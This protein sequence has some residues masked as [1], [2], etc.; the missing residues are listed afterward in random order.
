[1]SGIIDYGLVEAAQRFVEERITPN[2]VEWNRKGQVPDDVIADMG[3]LGL[4]GMLLPTEYGGAG[5]NLSTFIAVIEQIAA[6]D[7][8]LSTLVHVHNIGAGLMVSRIGSADQKDKWLSDMATGKTLSAVCLTEPSTGSDLSAVQT[9]ATRIEGGWVLSGSKQFIS[10][11][12]R[13]GL[14]IVLAVTDPGAGSRGKSFFLV[15]K[16]TK[17]LSIGSQER[18]MGQVT[19]D[20]VQVHFDECFVPDGAE[21][22][23][24]GAALPLI[25]ELLSDGRISIAAQAI[26]MARA[27]YNLALNY[28]QERHAFGRAIF[29]HQAVAFRLADMFTQIELAHVYTFNAA[30]LY[31]EGK[32]CVREA[33]VA[34]LFSSEMAERV[35]SDAIQIHGGNGYLNDYRVEQIARDVR[36]CQ[37][38]EGT[39][40]IQ[41]LI[42][43]RR[44]REG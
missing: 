20:T 15:P 10:N 7:G 40:D 36:V 8:G 39:S 29:D 11:G 4:F 33:S 38:Y 37:I 12:A 26:G 14:I 30:R 9:R 1:M 41:R 21:L 43:A 3:K 28:A 18:K 17:G 22:G 5:C 34:K 2:S 13:A 23:D 35:C 44:I 6:G 42:I 19:S 32:E 31:D 25:M 24:I 27:A 16:G